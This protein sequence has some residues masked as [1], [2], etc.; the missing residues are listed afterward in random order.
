MAY[1]AIGVGMFTSDG[2]G[3]VWDGQGQGHASSSSHHL[4]HQR[5]DLPLIPT[6]KCQHIV[7]IATTNG[8][9]IL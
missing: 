4:Q 8:S 5:H 2:T 3:Q 1:N 7:H 6:Q 9:C